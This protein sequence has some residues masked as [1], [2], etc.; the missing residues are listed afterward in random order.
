MAIRG[1]KTFEALTIEE[2]SYIAGFF[3]GEGNINI[4]K[5]DTDNNTNVQQRKCPKY[6]LTVA[7][8]NTDKEI[9]DWL[10]SVFGGYLQV[11]NSKNTTNH[12]QEW[13]ESYTQKLTSN[14]ALEFLNLVYPYLRVKKKQAEVAMKFQEVK[15]RKTS[16]FAKITP[17]QLV[18]FESSYL[19]LRK[20][21][22]CCRW[23]LNNSTAAKRLYPQRLS[24]KTPEMVKR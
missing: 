22:D 14:Q 2:I 8:Y 24:E 4:Y 3:D 23:R 11:R 20:L 6:E 12:K 5:I 1:K 16:R 19:Q 10:H 13:K 7:I 15:L 9:M 18:F 21:I 17:E